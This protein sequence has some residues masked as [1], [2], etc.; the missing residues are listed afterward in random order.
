[1]KVS[2]LL[3]LFI[4]IDFS[5][6]VRTIVSFNLLLIYCCNEISCTN[7]SLNIAN[8][9]DRILVFNWCLIYSFF[10]VLGTTGITEAYE[11]RDSRYAYIFF[12]IVAL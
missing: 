3:S 1:M 8:V 2:V 10:P 4:C 12:T 11:F 6:Y 7:V 5:S 9:N